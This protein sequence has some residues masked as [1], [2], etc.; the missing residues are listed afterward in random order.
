MAV[1][2]F[3][4]AEVFIPRG[5]PIDVALGKA[6]YQVEPY[7]SCV[8]E[9][10]K[11]YQDHYDELSVTKQYPLDVD[12]E[13]YFELARTGRLIV[14]TC[15]KNGELIGYIQF[16]IARNLHYK[17]MMMACE[18]IYYLVKSHRTGRTGINMFKFAESYMRSIGINRI[19]YTTKVHLDNS[20]IFRYL[21]YSFIEK[22]YSKM[23]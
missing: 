14:V 13:G 1:D 18:D 3:A 2:S 10:K 20:S 16:I 19:C 11:H 7:A 9:L 17:T 6:T 5:T 21:G 4:E 22:L 23:L 15:R 8:E 12:Y